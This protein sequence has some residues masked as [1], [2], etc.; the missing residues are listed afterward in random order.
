MNSSKSSTDPIRLLVDLNF[1]A[2]VWFSLF[3]L[4]ALALVGVLAAQ[5]FPQRLTTT[6]Y[7]VVDSRGASML[8]HEM[9][10]TEATNVQFRAAA[11]ATL[12]LLDRRPND[13]D[14]PEL[15]AE[16]YMPPA[17][18]KAREWAERERPERTAR[19]LHQK[20]EP[21][22][23]RYGRLND[24]RVLVTITG[25]LILV[26]SIGGQSLV[27]SARFQLELQLIHNPDLASN[28]RHPL[29]V[30]NFRYELLPR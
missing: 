30:N 15:L 18:A 27:D 19:S 12:A 21:T 6:R 13:F 4:E 16:L 11:D 23:Y 7:V 24:Q 25:Q 14:H 1:A 2:K 10:L 28:A 3:L 26:G 9:P 17:L 20:A 8:G 22:H 29:V 5:L